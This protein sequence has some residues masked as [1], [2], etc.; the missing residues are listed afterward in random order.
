MID[1]KV[2][3]QNGDIVVEGAEGNDVTLFDATGRLLATRRDDYQPLHFPV[4]ATGTYF[5][6]IANRPARKV[7]I[8]K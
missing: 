4:P 3:V 7:L 5:V 8:A 6:S 1:A 2:Y